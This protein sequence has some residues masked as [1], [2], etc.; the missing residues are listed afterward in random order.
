MYYFCFGFLNFQ[1]EAPKGSKKPETGPAQ[2][3]MGGFG[4]M[5][6]TV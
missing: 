6:F 4:R 5:C 3:V 2:S 1:E